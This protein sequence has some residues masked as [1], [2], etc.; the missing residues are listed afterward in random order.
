MAELALFSVA[1]A[2]GIGDAHPTRQSVAME[3]RSLQLN[4]TALRRAAND[5]D[6]VAAREYRLRIQRTQTGPPREAAEYHGAFHPFTTMGNTPES[7]DELAESAAL[8]NGVLPQ[9]LE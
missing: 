3:I 8:G 5:R 6:E 7:S 1:K 4:F 2:G 9:A